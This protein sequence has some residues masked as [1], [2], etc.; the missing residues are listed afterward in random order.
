MT[1]LRALYS[2]KWILTT[3]LVIAAIGVMARL[4]IWQL[5]RLEQ[6]KEFNMRVSS[7]IGLP[8]LRLSVDTVG[9]DLVNMEYREV[10]VIGVYDHAN[11]VA[12][13]NQEH[14]GRLGVRLLTPLKISGS[15]YYILVNRGWIPD[16]H[17]QTDKWQQYS[18]IGEVQVSGVIRRSES[19][20]SFGGIPDPTLVP[21]E[22]RLT[23][24]NII[25]L[26]R[27]EEE[28][29]LNMLPFYIQEV[30]LKS[31]DEQYPI[32]KAPELNLTEGSH[33]GYA[34]QW[35]LFASILAIGYPFYIKSHLDQFAEPSEID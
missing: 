3:A 8:S 9:L 32:P 14:E 26:V 4:G 7:Q 24:W 31:S 15:E 29:G 13:R 6:R 28:S 30:P 10:E 21:G 5:D 23:Q 25:N 12:L 18:T 27:I 19:K 11:E 1:V 17:S 2:G 20:P 35:F 33:L 34:V 22:A 16:E